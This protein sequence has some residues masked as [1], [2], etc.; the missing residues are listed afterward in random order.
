MVESVSAIGY[1]MRSESARRAEAF[2]KRPIPAGE[3]VVASYQTEEGD[4][5]SVALV[6]NAGYINAIPQSVLEY[7]EGR[8]GPGDTTFSPLTLYVVAE[9]VNGRARTPR[10]PIP[11]NTPIYIASKDHIRKLYPVAPKSVRIGSLELKGERVEISVDPNALGYHLLIAG[12][13]GSGK[14][15]TV[16]VLIDRLSA[17]G[18]PVIVFDVHGEYNIEPEDGDRTRVQ[19][20]EPAINPLQLPVEIIISMITRGGADIQRA[21][22]KKAL[23]EVNEVWREKVDKREVDPN[24]PNAVEQYESELLD[25]IESKEEERYQK[26]SVESLVMRVESFFETYKIN[27]DP[28]APTPLHYLS[29]GKILVVDARDLIDDEKRWYLYYLTKELLR[30]L[31]SKEITSAVLVIEEAPIFIGQDSKSHPV[32]EVIQRFA[33]EGRKFGGILV[34]VSQRPRSLDVNV[35][36]QL[37][38][39]IFLRMV[40]EEDIR[41]VMNI[42]DSLDESLA[43]IIPTLPDG[44]AIVMG[45][46]LG[47]FPAV[48]DIDLHKGKRVGATP[49]FTKIWEEEMAKRNERKGGYDI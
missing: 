40:Q 10:Y 46:F 48:V 16:A 8:V 17:M 1:V 13:T 26:K 37:Q 36:S 30:K 18:A 43:T 29:A 15:N 3:Y 20:Y 12:A 6:S 11:P 27:V 41:T 23:K 38:N 47:K 39:F 5:T 35:T 19:K 42:S 2:S 34:V 28:N 4:V 45:R 32:K 44:R 31:K 49:S 7:M 21:M 25:I 9:I 24:A 33:R 22:L 14:S